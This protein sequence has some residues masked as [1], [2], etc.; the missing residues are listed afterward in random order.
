M[1][2]PVPGGLIVAQRVHGVDGGLAALNRQAG[3]QWLR[4]DRRLGLGRLGFRPAG[5]G[6]L[7]CR[8]LR[9]RRSGFTGPECYLL[10][11]QQG[12]LLHLLLIVPVHIARD[13]DS[14]R[15]QDQGYVVALSSDSEGFV[16]AHFSAP[17]RL[18]IARFSRV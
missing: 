3:F 9:G 16:I 7:R 11:F 17:P 4:G 14:C 1:H 2:P 8:L 5:G 13:P 12:D 10:G 18:S 15:T 6:S